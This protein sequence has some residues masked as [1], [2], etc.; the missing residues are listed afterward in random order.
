MCIRDRYYHGAKNFEGDIFDHK[1]TGGIGFHFTP[2]IE[3]AKTFGDQIISARLRLDNPA[4][5]EI[6]KH[7]M[8]KAH[9]G[10]PRKMAIDYLRSLGYDCVIN[11][12]YETIVFEPEQIQIINLNEGWKDTLKRSVIPLGLAMGAATVGSDYAVSNIQ[13]PETHTMQYQSG[14]KDFD[15]QNSVSY[16]HLTLPTILR[17]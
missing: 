13:E 2:D 10:N 3:Q 11:P 15:Y 8:N 4:P 16:T 14:I 17:V 1:R 9:G 5:L 6:W 12:A 7:A